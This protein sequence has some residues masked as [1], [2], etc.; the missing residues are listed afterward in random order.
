MISREF[1]RLE[2][3]PLDPLGPQIFYVRPLGCPKFIN[4]RN[5]AHRRIQGKAPSIKNPRTPPR[6]HPGKFMLQFFVPF[7]GSD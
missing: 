1:A 3:C 5:V 7:L 4:V 6:G 2:P